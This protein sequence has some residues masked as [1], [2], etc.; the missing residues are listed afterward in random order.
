MSISIDDFNQTLKCEICN[1]LLYK[2]MTLLC[3]HTFCYHCLEIGKSMKTLKE[4][5]LCKLKLEIPEVVPQ[6]N[7]ISEIEKI[8]FGN[9][10]F[11][12]I[13]ARVNEEQLQRQLE[14]QVR[15]EI[16]EALKKTILKSKKED[17]K[18]ININ[19]NSTHNQILPE[20]S[21]NNNNIQRN[22]LASIN[23]DDE[24]TIKDI[25]RIMET[26]VFVFYVYDYFNK[27]IP[28]LSGTKIKICVY[29]IFFL[30]GLYLIYKYYK[31]NMVGNRHRNLQTYS[32]SY[33]MPLH[34]DN[35]SN[36][37]NLSQSI[38]DSMRDII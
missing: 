11:K 17:Y 35:L 32:F 12:S 29:S 20:P 26:L 28:F 34:T 2:P 36:V 13:E 23:N 18:N 16:Q 5:P 14:P 6:N 37:N 19:L 24:W 25:T 3:Q 27:I 38:I 8:I 30:V 1:D 10:H 4:C 22:N 21:T 7:L 31:I 9:E 33:I 15:Q